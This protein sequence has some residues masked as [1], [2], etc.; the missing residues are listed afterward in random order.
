[1]SSDDVDVDVDVDAAMDSVLMLEQRVAAACVKEAE[2][3]AEAAAR[4]DGSEMG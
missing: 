4:R 3:T 1:M 2:E